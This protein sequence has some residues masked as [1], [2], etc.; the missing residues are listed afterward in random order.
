MAEQ[1]RSV[2]TRRALLDAAAAV[3]D[4]QGYDAANISEI[5]AR[6][7]LTKGAMYFHFTSKQALAEAVMLEQSRHRPPPDPDSP[8]QTMIDLT[9]YVGNELRKNPMMRAGIRL[10]TEQGSFR[11]Q[12]EPA[13]LGWI[14][15]LEHLLEL[16][17]TRGQVIPTTCART[18]A[19]FLVGSF[20]GLQMLSG[21]LSDHDDL[22]ARLATLWQYV[23]PRIATPAVLPQLC[24]TQH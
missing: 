18:T 1:E 12:G 19:E 17:K 3:F 10:A 13:Y 16:A 23:L 24:V 15:I 8:V 6:A 11:R 2:R 4:E 5:L 20:T 9:R 21:E 14:D 22:P 7:G